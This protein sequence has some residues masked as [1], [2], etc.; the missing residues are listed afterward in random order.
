MLEIEAERLERHS[1]V[2]VTYPALVA[3]AESAGRYFD[4]ASVT[5]K[6]K[7][8]LLEVPGEAASKGRHIV[9]REDVLKLVESTT[10][11]PTGAPGGA[12]KQALLHLEDML[13]ARVVGQ[14]EAIKVVAEAL[15]RSRAGVKNPDK[16]I[17]TFLFLGPTGVGKT[18]TTKAL[19]D[20][21]FGSEAQM[22]RLDMSEY[23]DSHAVDRLIGSFGEAGLGRL[24]ELLREHPYGV[25]LLDEFEK[26]SQDVI[27]VFLRLF[28]EGTVTD[29]EGR[30]A[31]A[32]NTIMIATSNAGSEL[33]WDIV[34]SGG[35][36]N[37]RK[38]EVI[39]SIVASGAFKPELLNRFDAI[40]LFHPLNA[41][42]LRQIARLMM[43]R[44]AKRMLDRGIAIETKDRAID[45]LVAKGTDPKFGARPLARAIA[46]EAERIVSE[47]I[48][49]GEI[50]EGSRVAFDTD[51][52][53][54]LKIIIL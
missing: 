6:A 48:I 50:R 40:V 18:E 28:D 33:V 35:D 45:Y 13:R 42:D 53:G 47:K 49:E 38:Q 26:T 1:R 19:A 8:L 31:N 11:I 3:I 46:E 9:L 24:P 23:R 16:P 36:L 37:A 10:G 17:G 5:E 39:D 25:L 14:E 4:L 22:S 51:P 43:D 30:K 15:K 54:M 20:V 27:N 52:S 34:K 12:E 2:F 21:Y 41:E 7:D 44:F 29:T 32:K